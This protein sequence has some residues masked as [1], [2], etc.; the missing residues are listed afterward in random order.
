MNPLPLIQVALGAMVAGFLD[1][2]AGFGGTLLLIPV[3]VMVAGERDGVVLS[4]FGSL[5][6]GIT[7]IVLLR[8]LID[9]KSV[10]Y[11]GLGMLP[12]VAIGTYFLDTIS[13][14]TL[15]IAIGSV[16]ILFGLYYVARLY[17][18]LPRM[19]ALGRVWMPIIGV[20]AGVVA[21]LLGAGHG[22][23]TAAVMDA[24]GM[25]GREVAATGGALA[26]VGAVARMV[27]YSINGTLDSEL[28]LPGVICAAGG[29]LG[30][31]LGV[32]FSRRSGDSTIELLIGLVLLLAG[33]KMLLT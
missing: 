8:A 9:W 33:I 16:V 11:I 21:A 2:V 23:I 28:L 22:P 4:A 5:G 10:L 31:V 15:R 19:P 18:D 17:F 12:G 29:W 7:R 6:W 14:D 20:L 13:Q 1:T 26:G 24:S 30:A 25:S 27:A 32:R 3:L